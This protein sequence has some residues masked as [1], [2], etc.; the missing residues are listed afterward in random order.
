ME[1]SPIQLS[2]GVSLADDATFDNFFM[3]YSANGQVVHALKRIAK[4]EEV[5]SHVIWGASGAGLTHLLQAVC[6]TAPGYLLSTRYM[7]IHEL[8]QFNPRAIC[9]GV[10]KINIVCVDGVEGIAGNAQWEQT[11]FHLYN[12]LRDAGHV[13]IFSTHMNPSSLP[14]MLPDLKSR[15][16]GSIIYHVESLSDADKQHSLVMRAKARGM[17]MSDEVA[18]FILYR[19]PRDTNELF[20]LLNRLD[21]ASLREQRKL[22]VPF[23]KEVLGL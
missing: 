9:D 3:N 8:L 4:G 19:A 14:I 11:I 15:I 18:K 20:N 1:E 16:L 6:H 12:N 22:T 21:E 7:P 2:L 17:V 13:I 5:S 23:V 10:E